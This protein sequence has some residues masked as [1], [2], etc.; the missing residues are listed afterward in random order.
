M[1]T[2]RLSLSKRTVARLSG[3]AGCHRSI[4][5]SFLPMCTELKARGN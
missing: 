3:H 1:K 5:L 2:Q 4:V